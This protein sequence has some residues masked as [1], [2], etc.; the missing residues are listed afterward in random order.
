MNIDAINNEIKCI[1]RKARLFWKNPIIDAK[2]SDLMA[3][4]SNRGKAQAK[5]V[6]T[7]DSKDSRRFYSIKQKEAEAGTKW[8]L[9]FVDS[10]IMMHRL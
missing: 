8:E 1:N 9:S 2:I 10:L 4:L 7:G 6:M 5:L 3:A